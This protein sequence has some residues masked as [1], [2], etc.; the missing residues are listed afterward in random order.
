MEVGSGTFIPGFEDQLIGLEAG[1]EKD[2]EVTFPEEYHEEKL[3]GKPAVFKVKIH[4]IKTKELPALDDEFAKDVNDEVETL[5]E[6]KAKI[7]ERLEEQKNT[8][9][10]NKLRDELVEKAAEN[11]EVDIPQVMIDNE[12][13]RMMNEFQQRLLLQGLNLELYYQFSGQSE[14]EL[15]E[16][17]RKDAEKRVKYNLTLEAI[18]K[19]E[20]IDVTE[21]EVNEEL[22]K[23]ADMYNMPV[24]SVK[25]ALGSTEGI[26]EDLKIKKAVD[27]LVENR[28]DVA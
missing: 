4:E 1:E 22:Q 26:K 27:F 25:R 7:R 24:E 3:A 12:L 17:M 6:L 2:V 19:A 23:M 10:E 18:A 21:E 9:A 11:V 16:Q 15:R 5:E 8:Q 28:K 13:E 20:N 14:E